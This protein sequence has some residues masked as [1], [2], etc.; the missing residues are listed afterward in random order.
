MMDRLKLQ[1]FELPS[2]FDV[3]RLL[4]EREILDV[5]L[6]CTLEDSWWQIADR[7]IGVKYRVNFGC[8]V[9]SVIGGV[10][11]YKIC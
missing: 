4:V 9:E 7:S 5:D 11:Q 6:A 8:R 2:E 1:V 10:V 3:T